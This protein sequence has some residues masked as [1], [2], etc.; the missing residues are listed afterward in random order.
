MKE[1][2]QFEHTV[3]GLYGHYLDSLAGFR[4]LN[5]KGKKDKLNLGRLLCGEDA[6]V[7][8]V[9]KAGA[10]CMYSY[11][12]GTP[13]DPDFIEIH[14]CSYDAYIARNVEL[15]MNQW[16]AG[17]MFVVNVFAFWQ[18]FHRARIT[19]LLGKQDNE[20]KTPIMGDLRWYRQ[21]ILHRNGKAVAGVKKCEILKWYAEDEV[22]FLDQDKI[23]HIMY[24]LKILIRDLKRQHKQRTSNVSLN[25]D[26]AR[27]E[28]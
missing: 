13:G 10:Q 14:T 28:Q 26:A 8:E 9:T 22:I 5:E 19:S 7:D 4:H 6:N 24:H 18:E 15:G 25:A 17:T 23:A 21:S 2:L 12:D 1:I 11:T 27:Q 20:L 16:F 3:D